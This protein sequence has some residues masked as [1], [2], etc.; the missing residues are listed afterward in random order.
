M[1]NKIADIRLLAMDVDGVL[2]SGDI[3]YADNAI[4]VKVFNIHDGLALALS[5]NAGLLTAIITGRSSSAIERRAAELKIDD[6]IQDVKLKSLAVKSLCAKYSLDKKNIAFVGDDI[7]DIPA[8]SEAGFRIAVANA[9][10][11]LKLKADYVTSKH[12]GK[13]AIREVIELILRTQGKWDT[14]M[15]AFLQQFGYTNE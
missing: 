14:A 8:F 3:I 10:D 13:G 11:D 1:D 2:T 7:N 6:V 12:G 5:K 4:E 9:S 15:N